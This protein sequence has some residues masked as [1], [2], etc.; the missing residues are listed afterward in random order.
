MKRSKTVKYFLI[1]LLLA[2]PVPAQP[3]LKAWVIE[4]EYPEYEAWLQISTAVVDLGLP[5]STFDGKGEYWELEEA[6]V[7]FFQCRRENQPWQVQLGAGDFSSGKHTIHINSLYWKTRDGRYNRM[8]GSGRARLAE[9]KDYPGRETDLHILPLSFLVEPQKE[10]IKI[11]AGE[12]EA[13]VSIT[14]FFP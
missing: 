5:Q 2:G 4:D 12:Y 14:L 3:L 11:P 13:R 9:S 8:P 10:L 6:L 7:V 1:I